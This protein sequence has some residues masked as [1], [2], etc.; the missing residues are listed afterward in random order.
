VIYNAPSSHDGRWWV[1]D[2]GAAHLVTIESQCDGV[3]STKPKKT[4]Y[5]QVLIDP[6]GFIFNV[7]EGGTYDAVTGI[8][9]P[10]QALAGMTITAYV[11]VPEWQTWTIW[12]A[13]KYGQINP[14]V[15]DSSGYFAF[16]TPPGQYYLQVDA[17]NGYQSW[18]SPVVTV[19][20]ELVHVNIPMTP[21]AAGPGSRV[22]LT[23]DGPQPQVIYAPRGGSVEWVSTLAEDASAADLLNFTENPMMQPRSGGLL[24]PIVNILGFDGGMLKPGQ[25]FT[26]QFNAIGEYTYSDNLGHT[27]L[28]KVGNIVYIPAALR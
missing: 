2:I 4:T 17:T 18:R 10:M 24:D 9:T 13:E 26:R 25:T 12:P 23:P 28:V 21:L 5:G 8:Y 20:N 7:D 27:G 19:V 11:Y 22:T 6:D 3:G 1:F 16:F 15:T 14:Q